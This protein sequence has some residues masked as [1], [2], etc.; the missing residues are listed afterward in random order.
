MSFYVLLDEVK[1]IK[2][3]AV[4]KFVVC[5]IIILMRRISVMAAKEQCGSHTYNTCFRLLELGMVII[6]GRR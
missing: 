6:G 5:V 3:L 4:E 2:N 1:P